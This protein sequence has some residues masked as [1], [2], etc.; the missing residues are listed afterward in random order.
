MA[1]SWSHAAAAW[2]LPC[3]CTPKMRQRFH[4]DDTKF[5]P[6]QGGT[7]ILPSNSAV[8]M[9][10]LLHRQPH[11]PASMTHFRAVHKHYNWAGQYLGGQALQDSGGRASRHSQA[12]CEG[13]SFLGANLHRLPGLGLAPGWIC[14][15]LA[16]S[17]RAGRPAQKKDVQ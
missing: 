7:L 16:R 17:I 11:T 15:Q 5:A 14:C 3:I 1:S 8:R 6:F 10:W 12:A 9:A 2:D 4:P 13:R